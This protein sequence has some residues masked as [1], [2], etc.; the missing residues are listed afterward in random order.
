MKVLVA[1]ECSGVVREAFRTRGHDAWSCDT[2]PARDHSRFH[3]QMDARDLLEMR[4]QWDLIIA[5]PPCTYLTSCRRGVPVNVPERDK[6]LALVRFFLE[7]DCPRICI[8]NPVGAIASLA[9]T[10]QIIQPHWFGHPYT[11]RTG[12]WL[13]NLEPLRPTKFVQS[14]GPW[15]DVTFPRADRAYY[16]SRTFEGIASAMAEQWGKD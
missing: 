4:D 1:C 6:A 16:R 11:K 8:E 9:R 12:L 3:F 15:L 5:H 14:L 10:T 2:E 13:K 7:A